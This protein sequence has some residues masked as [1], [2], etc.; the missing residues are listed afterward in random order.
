MLLA[1]IAVLALTAAPPPAKNGLVPFRIS[2]DGVTVTVAEDGSIRLTDEEKRVR[3]IGTLDPSG[4]VVV[5][6]GKILALIAADGT[7]EIAAGILEKDPV[8]MGKL[9]DKGMLRFTLKDNKE[10][11]VGFGPDG[12]LIGGDDS[13]RVKVTPAN[14]P[15]VNRHAMLLYLLTFAGV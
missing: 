8:R 12:L 10:M 9:D 3:F 15:T 7:V 4:K 6:G 11:K 13:N 14:N 5:A 2:G 1:A